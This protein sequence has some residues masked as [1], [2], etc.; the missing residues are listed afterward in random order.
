MPEALKDESPALVHELQRL[1][2]KLNIVLRLIA[3]LHLR[4]HGLPPR[5]PIRLSSVGLEWFGGDAPSGSGLLKVY[6]NDSLPHALKIPSVVAGTRR[7][8]DTEVTQL[9]FSGMSEAVV[10]LLDKFIFRHHRRMVAGAKLA[11]P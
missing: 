5:R 4:E 1:E 9:R 2:Y 11:A 8:G 6:L 10:A 7:Q 3:D